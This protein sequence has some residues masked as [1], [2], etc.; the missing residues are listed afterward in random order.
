MSNHKGCEFTSLV[1]E[2]NKFHSIDY[3]QSQVKR[4]ERF[5]FAHA[6]IERLHLEFTS[7][8]SAQKPTKQLHVT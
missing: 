8:K 4:Y 5:Q 3:N 7:E 1:S 2:L 6:N